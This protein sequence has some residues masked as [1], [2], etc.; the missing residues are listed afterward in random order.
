MI[1]ALQLWE[2]MKMG[3]FVDYLQQPLINREE[4]KVSRG[5]SYDSSDSPFTGDDTLNIL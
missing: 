1:L 5:N 2:Q 3:L 4:L